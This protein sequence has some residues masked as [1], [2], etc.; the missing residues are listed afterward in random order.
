MV[1]PWQRDK[2][3]SGC[4]DTEHFS[5]RHNFHWHLCRQPRGDLCSVPINHLVLIK[6]IQLPLTGWEDTRVVPNQSVF[7]FLSLIW[8]LLILQ[9]GEGMGAKG[10]LGVRLCFWGAKG[11]TPHPAA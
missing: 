9:G 3:E 4:F 5:T 10:V 6:G 7:L 8:Q 11:G 1:V 2:V